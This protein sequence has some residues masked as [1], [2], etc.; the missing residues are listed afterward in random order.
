MAGVED[1]VVHGGAAFAASGSVDDKWLEAIGDCVPRAPRDNRANLAGI[2]ASREALPSTP[3]V[4]VFDTA[5]HAR[6]P[7]RSKTY[8]LDAEL[9][10]DK[11][12]RRYGFHGTSHAYVAELAAKFL[13]RPLR[14]LRLVTCHLG[15]GASACAIEYGQSVDTSMGMTPIKI[16][17]T[18]C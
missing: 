4:A 3:Q 17:W 15:N 10:S 6:M 5:F 13:E 14:E 9:A 7:G 11:G 2:R 16:K 8:A 12:I 1:C 18:D